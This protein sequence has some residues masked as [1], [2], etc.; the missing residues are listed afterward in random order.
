[1]GGDSLED[2]Y[3]KVLNGSVEQFCGN[4]FVGVNLQTK[5]KGDWDP[6]G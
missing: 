3:K 6:Q 1:M 4:V 5:Y 2:K